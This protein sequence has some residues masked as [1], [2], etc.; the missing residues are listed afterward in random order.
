MTKPTQTN[1]A[2]SLGSLHYAW[3][4]L[5]NLVASWAAVAAD[6]HRG[7]GDEEYARGIAGGLDI[8]ARQLRDM[9]PR[10]LA[11]IPPCPHGTTH[12]QDHCPGWCW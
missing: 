5:N 9:L 11:A 2:V 10:L 12:D 8:A 3:H 6:I 7:D 1:G 4:D